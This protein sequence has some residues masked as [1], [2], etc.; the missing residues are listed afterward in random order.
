MPAN[1]TTPVLTGPPRNLLWTVDQFHHLGD[2]GM[3]EGRRA[4][5]IN[6]VIV[7]EGPMNPPH[8]IALE[9]S[10]NALRGAFGAGWRVCNQMPLVLGQTTDPEPDLAV[11]A[12]SPRG[13]STHPTSAALV[14]EVSDSSLR[15]D[16]TEK[17]SLYAAG[18]IADYW[19]V[20]VSGRQL[21][22][23]R[24]PQPDSTQSHGHGYAS[25]QVFGPNDA[26]APLAAPHAPVRV[27]DLVP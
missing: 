23:F 10:E 27:A 19:V 7:E 20:D 8:R 9:L 14:V 26:V 4:M 11:I 18:A 22:V 6:G 12:G 16:T 13:A 21:L 3:F 25:R 5:L 2:L 17:M 1:I 24:D 15:Y